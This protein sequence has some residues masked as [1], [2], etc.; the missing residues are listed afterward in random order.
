MNASSVY[1]RM[2]VVSCSPLCVGGVKS[3]PHDGGV[4]VGGGSF[5]NYRALAVSRVEEAGME[6]EKEKEEGQQMMMMDGASKA[7]ARQAPENVFED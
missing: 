3:V 6:V 5:I 4:G 1:T 2:P 7:S